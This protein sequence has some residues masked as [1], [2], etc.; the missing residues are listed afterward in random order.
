MPTPRMLPDEDSVLLRH[1]D[2]EGLSL[3][4]VARK[5]GVTKGAVSLRFSRM[6]RPWTTTAP[7]GYQDYLPWRILRDHQSLDAAQR[8]KA[9]IR[10]VLGHDV[11]ELQLRRLTNWHARLRRERVV[12][13]YDCEQSSPWLYVP[14]RESDGVSVIR[15]PNDVPAPTPEQL[16]VLALPD[17]PDHAQHE[18]QTTARS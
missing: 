17:G 2:F 13:V 11:S 5:Y 1:R 15:W 7:V 6:G 3:T 18:V 10:H 4:E 14:R 9:H 16:R 8:L 12:L